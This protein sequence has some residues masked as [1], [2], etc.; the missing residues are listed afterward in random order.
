MF[1]GEFQHTLDAKGRVS[2]PA[3]FRDELSG[4]LVVVEGLRGVPVR[5]PGDGYE[6][7]LDELLAGQRLRRRGAARAAVLHVGRERDASSTRPAASCSPPVLREYARA[8]R[9]TSRSSATATASRSGTPRRGPRT[10]AR[11]TEH[12][13]DAAGELA[14]KGIL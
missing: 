8:R 3:K 4:T 14:A 5:V 2:L 10:T 9:R 7:F 13:E 11:P 1:L 12:I 6:E